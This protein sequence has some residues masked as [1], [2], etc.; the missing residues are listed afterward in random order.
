[1]PLLNNSQ[2]VSQKTIPAIRPTRFPS[3]APGFG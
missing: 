2:L 1:M 3:A